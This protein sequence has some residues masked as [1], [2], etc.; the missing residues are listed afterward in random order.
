MKLFIHEA[1]ATQN[2]GSSLWPAVLLHVS[3][4]APRHV[5]HFVFKKTRKDVEHNH[6]LEMDLQRC[7]STSLH[8]VPTDARLRK[9]LWVSGRISCCPG[10]VR[11]SFNLIATTQLRRPSHHIFIT[12]GAQTVQYLKKSVPTVASRVCGIYT[13]IPLP[14]LRRLCELIKP[15]FNGK[16]SNLAT[17]LVHKST[18]RPRPLYRD[19]S[20]ASTRHLAC[21]APVCTPR[22]SS[23]LP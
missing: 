8:V 7:R 13:E 9:M 4:S 6:G 15:P 19:V 10:T 1:T 11:V 3:Q 18:P 21:S 20:L 23:L 22:K 5:G 2:R 14:V 16:A 12:T 17:P